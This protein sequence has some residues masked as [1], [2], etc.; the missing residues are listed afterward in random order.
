MKDFYKLLFGGI[1]VK[2]NP[3][4]YVEII[5]IIDNNDT[6]YPAKRPL[7]D[8]EKQIIKTFVFFHCDEKFSFIDLL[9][10]INSSQPITSDALLIALEKLDADGFINYSVEG[11]LNIVEIK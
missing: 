1:S 11:D 6:N 4:P 3:P 9:Y 7:T 8:V 5:D 2:R 10:W